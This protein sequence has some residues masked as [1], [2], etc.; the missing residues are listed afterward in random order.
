[1]DCL[2]APAHTFTLGGNHLACAAG[3]AAMDVYESEEFR[4]TLEE[5]TALLSSLIAGLESRHGDIIG[6]TRGLGMSRGIVIV[7]LKGGRV[8]PDG[9]GSFKIICRAYELG[10]I[11]ITVSDSIIRIQPPLNISRENLV[12]SFELLSSAMDDFKAGKIGD[13]VLVHRRGCGI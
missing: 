8:L 11:A 13:D 7:K 10:L 12:R 5:N 1:M 4:R 6:F 2:P 3:L 9:D